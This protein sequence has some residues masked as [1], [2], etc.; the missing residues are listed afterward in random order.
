MCSPVPNIITPNN[1]RQNDR[2]VINERTRGPWQ[3]AIYSRW[4][5]RLYHS[6]DYQNDWGADAP[7]GVYYYL[8][9]SAVDGRPK[10]GWLEVLR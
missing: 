3:I 9:Q 6:A 7:A 1:D 5:Q 10:K 2:F 4:G 8:L